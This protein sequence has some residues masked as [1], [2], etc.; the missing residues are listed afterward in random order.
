MKHILLSND[1]GFEAEGLKAAAKALRDLGFKVSIVSPATEK[2]A[3]AHSLTLT[4]PLR[5]IKI[6]TDFYKLDDGTPSDCIYLG[7]HDLFSNKKPDLIISGINHG[8]NLGEDITYS[9]TCAAAME[10][11]LH[12]I[13]SIA[14]SQFYK[15][16]T[17]KKY[18]FNLATKLLSKIVKDVFKKGWPLPARQFLNLNVPAVSESNFKGIKIT[19]A[20]KRIYSTTA[21][22]S[23]NP[24]GVE[25]FWLGEASLDYKSK[26]NSDL[27]AVNEGYASL[28]PIQLDL[29]AYESLKLIKKW[30]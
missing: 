5:L 8:G 9:G 19:K 11:I 26:K 25:Y 1:D 15:K 27:D 24:R 2:S 18:G 30:L 12:G 20:G 14:V 6:D 3:C 22:K 29:T 10:G 4:R 17:L 21:T 13:P 28:T 16:N 7:L 23:I